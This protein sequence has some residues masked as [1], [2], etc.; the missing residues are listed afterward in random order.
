MKAL[1]KQVLEMTRALNSALN[2]VKALENRIRSVESPPPL[3]EV[4]QTP[5]CAPRTEMELKEISQLPDRVK[6]LQPFDGN[7]NQYLSWLHCVESILD[8]YEI[9]RSKPIYRAILQS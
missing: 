1:Q 8:D 9:V 2:Q 6:E 7:P 4:L 5:A 3:L